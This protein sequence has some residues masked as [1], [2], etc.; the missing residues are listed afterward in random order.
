LLFDDFG[1]HVLSCSSPEFPSRIPGQEID[2]GERHCKLVRI[3]R[4]STIPNW[5]EQ[6]F[7]LHMF[8]LVMPLELI[9]AFAGHMATGLGTWER[10][11][12]LVAT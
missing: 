1:L 10:A 3:T 9:F 4:A 6:V 7:G 2:I 8:G 12:R 5:T 11:N